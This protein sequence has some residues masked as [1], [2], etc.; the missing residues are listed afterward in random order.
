MVR[1]VQATPAGARKGR[2]R[3]RRAGEAGQDEYRRASGDCRPAGHPVDPGGHRLQERPAGGRLHGRDPESQIRDFIQR[4]VGKNGAQ[5]QIAEALAAAKQAR[6]AGDLQGAAD[7]YDAVLQEA[8]E[9]LDA[10]AGLADLLFES[11]DAEGA[12]ELLDRAP[13]DKQNATAIAAL[14]TKIALAAEAAKLGDPTELERKLAENP[15]DHQARFD[16]A[17]LQN[18]QGK[19]QEAADNLLA[20]IKADRAWNEDGA[21]SQ[22]VKFFEAW[23]PTDE[24]TLSARRKT[25]VGS[26]FLRA[27]QTAG[28]GR[29]DLRFPPAAP[30][31]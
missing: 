9:T 19:R 26:V 16:L 31:C 20:I 25:L 27:G 14:R 22:L 10:I 24:A 29:P 21:R 13:A 5:P 1:A 3:G 18:A 17:M 30:D 4:L 2:R 15:R 7:L 23:G 12:K 8:P 6:E 28:F 11:G